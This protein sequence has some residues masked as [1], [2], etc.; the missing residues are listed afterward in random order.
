MST[1]LHFL[2]WTGI[3][4]APQ[5]G[6]PLICIFIRKLIETQDRVQSHRKHS[7]FE[8]LGWTLSR[9]C[10][11]HIQCTAGMPGASCPI[12]QNLMNTC[13]ASFVLLPLRGSAAPGRTDWKHL[14]INHSHI[15][16]SG[17]IQFHYCHVYQRKMC[18]QI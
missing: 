3:I 1:S 2:M 7:S 4:S 16:S 12:H 17:L 6:F 5:M 18:L 15:C 9:I 8:E 14:L 10:G 13:A 11:G